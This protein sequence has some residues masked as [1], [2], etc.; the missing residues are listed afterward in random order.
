M[1]NSCKFND[2]G[3]SVKMELL[4]RGKS[5][6]WL[7]AEIKKNTGMFVDSS[8]LYKIFTGQRKADKI[9]EAIDALLFGVDSKENTGTVCCN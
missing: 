5:Q 1:L 2:F 3:L 7:I 9:V 6:E 4:R 8:Y